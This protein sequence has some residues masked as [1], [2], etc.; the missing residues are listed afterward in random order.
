V[1]KPKKS[2]TRWVAQKELLDRANL[3]AY[4]LASVSAQARYVSSPYHRPPG[5]KM[6]QPAS[7]RWP[8]AS[9]CDPEWTLSDANAALKQAIRAGYI[10]SQWEGRFP[11][12]VWHLEGETVYEAR[13]SNRDAGEYHAYPLQDKREW[14]AGMK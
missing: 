12:Y 5:S 9:K 10:S 14:P 11:R 6:G 2:S 3:A 4:N 13:L 8:A 7:R 1:K